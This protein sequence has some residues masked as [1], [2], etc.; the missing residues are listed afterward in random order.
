TGGD[1]SGD[2]EGLNHGSRWKVIVI[3]RLRGRDAATSHPKEGDSVT[4]HGTNS[5]R[6]GREY[7]R[8]GIR[9]RRRR[10][11]SSVYIKRRVAGNLLGEWTKSDCLGRLIDHTRCVGNRA[12]AVVASEV[13]VVDRES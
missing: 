2:V 4:A 6:C 3:T 11:H 12:H 13:A 7:H 1:K 8:Q 10:T 9:R 5:G